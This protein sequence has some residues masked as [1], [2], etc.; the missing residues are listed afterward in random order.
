[1]FSNEKDSLLK[2]EQTSYSSSDEQGVSTKMPSVNSQ[3]THCVLGN[4]DNIY[5][6]DDDD[7]NFYF[8]NSFF[9]YP[10]F[11]NIFYT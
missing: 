8:L 10:S 2:N 1:M 3:E 11:A 4:G 7:G 6:D 9:C 5:G